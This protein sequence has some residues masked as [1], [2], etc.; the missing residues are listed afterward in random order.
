M[1][2]SRERVRASLNHRQPDRV[3]IDIDGTICSGMHVTCVAALREYYGL[4]KRPVKV[5]E[6]FQMLGLIEDDLREALG[7]DVR[8]VN[9]PR[10]FFGFP[11]EGWKPW[12]FHDIDVLVPE[13]FRVTT[14]ADGN[15]YIH[16]QGD[17]SAPAS[18]RLPK[19]GFYFDAIIRQEPFEES[20]LDPEDNLE[21]FQPISDADLEYFRNAVESV[22]ASGDAIVANFGGTGLGDVA[23]VPGPAL[24]HPKG[25]RDIA[26]W[27]MSTAIRQDFVRY[28][29]DKQTEIAVSNLEKLHQVVGDSIDV[30]FICG[31]DFGTQ[32]S[33][34]CSEASFRDLWMPY[35]KRVNDWVHANT[36]WKTF[37]HCCGAIEPF[38][39]AFI[40]S[41]FDILNPV[42]CSAAGMDPEL[43]KSKYGDRIVFWGGGVDTQRT[44][45]FGTPK[46]VREQVL[47]RCDV[48]SKNGGFVFSAIHNIQ[49][50]TPVE[51]IVA[52]VDAVHEFNGVGQ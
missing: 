45:P 4:E 30:V 23:L 43:L 33:T 9:G 24:K 50:N 2:G 15:T 51:N 39:N 29:F 14:D 19:S 20:D 42:Q 8:G 27:Y 7:L 47:R 36:G 10:G 18:G 12:R 34:F 52:M 31:T 11:N 13:G 48:F 22:K 41:G 35:Y 3:P 32:T 1:T 25:I 5:Y 17:L 38:I 28:I 6:P 37:K 26:E 49:A 21:E 44:L 16:P 46:E 40:E